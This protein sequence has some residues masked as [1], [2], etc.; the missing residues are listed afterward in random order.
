MKQRAT[1]C[2]LAPTWRSDPSHH[3]DTAFTLIELLVVVVIIAV[4]AAILLPTLARAKEQGYRTMCRSNLRQWGFA[5]Q[6]YANENAEAFPYNGDAGDPMIEGGKTMEVFWQNY[7]LP[8]TAS[9]LPKEK[10]HIL[11]CPTD[12]L[13]RLVDFG[14]RG[15]RG[16]APIIGYSY[17]PAHDIENH[18]RYWNVELTGVRG[19]HDRTKLG[20][21]YTKAPVVADHLQGSGRA[22]SEVDIQV[23]RWATVDGNVLVPYSSHPGQGYVPQGGNFL[24]ED[25]HV[26]W[27]QWKAIALGSIVHTGDSKNKGFLMFYKIPVD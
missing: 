6:M 1:L 4:L 10:N 25:S 13:H 16:E 23:F 26:A 8:H 15:P 20:G 18:P 27:F 9:R 17:M 7:L 21:E 11:F 19:W 22:Q 14:N 12:K 2:S 5:I 3:S 24:F